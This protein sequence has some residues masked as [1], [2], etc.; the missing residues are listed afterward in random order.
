[1]HP[2]DVSLIK[3]QYF[4][5]IILLTIDPFD[6]SDSS[7]L[8]LYFDIGAVELHTKSLIIKYSIYKCHSQK[9][10]YHLKKYKSAA[11]INKYLN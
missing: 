4:G 9:S 5:K 1:M 11:I 2:L 7:K 10:L 3:V 8:L 6:I